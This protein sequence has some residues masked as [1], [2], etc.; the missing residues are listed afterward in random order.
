MVICVHLRPKNYDKPN[1]LLK[2]FSASGTFS[3]LMTQQIADIELPMARSGM[4]AA[5]NVWMIVPG[6]KGRSRW[7]KM[8]SIPTLVTG[9]ISWA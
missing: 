4:C 7:G 2:S 8:E 5:L 9:E 3:S 6:I 1:F